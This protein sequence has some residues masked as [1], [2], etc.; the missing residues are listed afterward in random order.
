MQGEE[1]A[2]QLL[3]MSAGWLIQPLARFLP[4]REVLEAR[5]SRDR[6][7]ALTKQ[8]VS[9]HRAALADG[10]QRTPDLNPR[11]VQPLRDRLAALIR[12]PVSQHRDAMADNEQRTPDMTEP[13][14]QTRPL[15][16]QPP[17]DRLIVLTV[18]TAAQAPGCGLPCLS[19]SL[20]STPQ[21]LNP[22][23]L[24]SGL[25]ALAQQHAQPFTRLASWH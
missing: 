22:G 13:Q 6:L 1:A 25:T 3:R 17:C 19:R 2:Q 11:Q 16:L 20:I 14:S 12:Q 5:R 24:H 23:R 21:A 8:L 18:L 10:E 7:I 9:Q 15:I 4:D